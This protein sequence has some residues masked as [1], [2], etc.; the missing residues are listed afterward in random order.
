[1]KPKQFI[2]F[3]FIAATLNNSMAEDMIN[4]KTNAIIPAPKIQVLS[5]KITDLPSRVTIT[6]PE[7]M[8]TG[9]GLD[10]LT[11]SLA[12]Q[13][14]ELKTV[15]RHEDAF[16]EIIRRSP[17]D[18]LAGNQDASESYELNIT[19][20]KIT[21]HGLT[22]KAVFY[23]I[24]SLCQLIEASYDGTLTA[25]KIADF[26][27]LGIRGISD[28]ISRGQVSTIENFKRIIRFIAKYKMNTYMP[29][30]EDMLRFES[31]PQIG[32]GRGAL[33]KNEVKEIIEY[34]GK[35]FVEVIPIFQT[36]G[37][38]ENILSMKEFVKYAE[39]PGAAS[40]CVTDES[41][42]VFLENMLKEVFGLFPSEYFH[43]GADESYDVGLGR[44]KDELENSTL[45][46]LHAGHYK[47][48][49]EICKKYNKK[50]M[51]YGDIILSHP[52]I[53][54]KI[55]EDIVIV[56]WH[57]GINFDYESTKTFK[58][59]GF[60]YIVSPSVW[61]FTS[62][63][64]VYIN[65]QPNIKYITGSGIENSSI[66]IINSNWG[67]YGAETIKELILP[68]YAWSAQCGWNFEGSNLPEFYEV[69]FRQFFKTDSKSSLIIHKLLSNSFNQQYWHS[70]W[71]HPLLP[72]RQPVWWESNL[73]PAARV[74]EINYSNALLKNLINELENSALQNKEYIEI[75]SYLVDFNQWYSLKLLTQTKLHAM[76]DSSEAV[77]NLGILID[78]NIS[79]LTQLKQR[80]AAIWKKY[81]K[82]A[83]LNMIEDKFSRLITYFDETKKM[84][85][86]GNV[87][88]P[89]IESKWI[90]CAKDS[91]EFYTDAVFQK[92]IEIDGEIKSAK[93]QLL[94]DTFA[95]LYINNEFIDEVYVRRSLSLWGEYKRIMYKDIT[96]FLKEGMNEIRVEVKNYNRNPA[97]GFNL[98]ALIETNDDSIKLI[99]DE[100]WDAKSGSGN[101]EWEKAV[102]RI[103][104]YTV[105]A[106]NF[107]TDR[108]SWI[109]R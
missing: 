34:A 8:N 108:T 69:F 80:Y 89:E 47:R 100:T 98:I 77:G 25:Q 67:D 12:L 27:D 53:L 35:Y 17:E 59:A 41:V 36:L 70:V 68:G 52:E 3:I 57:Y 86:E 23:G 78:N 26:P 75:L 22:E 109:E 9:A 48:V 46:D 60:D 33:T 24:M 30:M 95:K 79:N 84:L 14:R 101:S 31:Y 15:G 83:N 18:F 65:S 105:I 81:Y 94:G 39:F 7:N 56:D 107:K 16:I 62:T 64:P 58:E 38:Y 20:G 66:G 44:S 19:P 61:N 32:E 72:Y 5:D 28:D 76:Q 96:E 90:Y 40:L 13:N 10:E 21:I 43:M 85:T 87:I 93:L 91:N 45:A 82:S 4:N 6:I 97:A 2:F 103:Y 74:E 29:Y 55:P 102:S 1:M 42:Y 50:V 37:H 11:I 106:P 88:S 92:S 99:S 63:Y 73:S 104:N 49:Y 54:E 71:R 51:M